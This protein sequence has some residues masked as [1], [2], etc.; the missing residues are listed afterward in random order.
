MTNL[1][2]AK[3][4]GSAI[5]PDGLSIPVIIQRITDLRKDGKVIC[6]FSAPLTI[7]DGKTRSITD[8]V[9]DIGRKAESSQ[10]FNL[11]KV[12]DTYEKILELVSSEYQDI[13]LTSSISAFWISFLI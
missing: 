13:C 5:G 2:V 1:V 9:L 8:I 12:R 4:G 7:E 11:D 10:K 6:V 3:F